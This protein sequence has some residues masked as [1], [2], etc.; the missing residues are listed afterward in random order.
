MK[1]KI[2]FEN[3][4]IE[5][6]SYCPLHEYDHALK[7]MWCAFQEEGVHANTE[8]EMVWREAIAELE[9][10]CPLEVVK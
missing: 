7:M 10:K 4:K 3:P 9:M 5:D 1:Y 8:K 2:I 6:C